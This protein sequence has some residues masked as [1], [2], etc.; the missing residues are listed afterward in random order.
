MSVEPI[1]VPGNEVINLSESEEE[2]RI[3]DISEIVEEIRKDC[4]HCQNPTEILQCAQNKIL[5]GRQLDITDP[6]TEIFGDKFY[7]S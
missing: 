2:V 7:F 6:T 4:E 3:K 5:T 1:N